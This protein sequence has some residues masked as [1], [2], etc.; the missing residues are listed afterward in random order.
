L[1][2]YFCAVKIPSLAPVN[3]EYFVFRFSIDYIY[4]YPVTSACLTVRWGGYDE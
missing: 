4:Q 3:G 1:L 2:I